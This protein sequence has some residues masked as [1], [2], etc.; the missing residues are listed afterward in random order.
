MSA[1]ASPASP[2]SD[3]RTTQAR[4][5][6]N[7][8]SEHEHCDANAVRA[9]LPR[10]VALPPAFATLTFLVDVVDRA[11]GDHRALGVLDVAPKVSPPR[12]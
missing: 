10:V 8:S 2:A 6:S 1:I 7:G 3:D 12:A 11:G 5:G 9:E 4:A